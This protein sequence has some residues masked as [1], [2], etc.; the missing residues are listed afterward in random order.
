MHSFTIKG[1]LYNIL[2]TAIYLQQNF[3]NRVG[4]RE[5]CIIYFNPE[6]YL[7]GYQESITPKLFLIIYFHKL[8]NYKNY[9]FIYFYLNFI[10]NIFYKNE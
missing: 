1:V 5:S 10:Y 3:T 8:Q 4:L 9:I 7:K 2:Y 6:K